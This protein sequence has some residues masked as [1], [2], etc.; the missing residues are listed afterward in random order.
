M[1]CS[2]VS[3]GYCPRER[4]T[5]PSSRVVIVPSA[6]LSNSENASLNSACYDI[7]EPRSGKTEL[8]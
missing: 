8:N 7:S 3:V 5:V 4:I 2:S 6:S 1:A